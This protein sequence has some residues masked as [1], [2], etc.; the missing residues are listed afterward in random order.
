[1][2]SLAFGAFL[3]ALIWLVRMI[4][5]YIDKQIRDSGVANSAVK[6]I[7]C[8]IRCCLDCCHRFIKFLNTNAY[9][10][11]A[12]TGK[13]FCPAAMEAFALA[14]KNAGSFVITNGIGYLITFLGKLMIAVGNSVIGYLFLTML[15]SI[16][17]DIASPISPLIVVAAISY[18]MAAIFMSI[19]GTT[20]LTLLQCLYADVDI[21]KQRQYDEFSSKYRP[22]EMEAIV[23]RLRKKD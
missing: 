21:C 22:R 10:Q 13:N 17:D 6:A 1:M 15:P 3:L 16:K 20:S 5:E 11:V 12:L 4:F 23:A 14:L 18:V 19:F 7:E 9:I 8:A 2:G